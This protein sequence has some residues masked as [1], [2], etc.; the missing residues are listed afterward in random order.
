MLPGDGDTGGGLD[1]TDESSYQQNTDWIP[2]TSAP[3]F[4]IQYANH[5]SNVQRPFQLPNASADPEL[6]PLRAGATGAYPSFD[7]SQNWNLENDQQATLYGWPG[8]PRQSAFN[9]PP[10]QASIASNAFRNVRDPTARAPVGPYNVASAVQGH[11]PGGQTSQRN[12]AN[13]RPFLS[14][15]NAGES[16]E[17]TPARP[18][19]LARIHTIAQEP[20]SATQAQQSGPK[21]AS[22]GKTLSP[23]SAQVSPTRKRRG[24]QRSPSSRQSL[25]KAPFQPNEEE[26]ARRI[27][28]SSLSSGG[29]LTSNISSQPQGMSELEPQ[30]PE[31]N[32]RAAESSML[33]TLGAGKTPGVLRTPQ[34]GHASSEQFTLPPGKGFPIQIGSELFRLSGASIM[35]DCQ[36]PASNLRTFYVLRLLEHLH[37][38]RGSSKT[39][40]AKTKMVQGL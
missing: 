35:S 5:L 15:R 6:A 13:Q 19:S 26:E 24:G 31:S 25:P 2:T 21:S 14:P 18:P 34:P 3:P 30:V 10:P 16:S 17:T 8:V 12:F 37:T 9:I 1:W 7:Q 40:S 27:H 33:D 36:C 11:D 38:F 4:D 22:S 20:T 39:R 32:L 23:S 28:M 29:S